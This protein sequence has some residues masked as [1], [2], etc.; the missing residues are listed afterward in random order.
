[1]IYICLVYF[2]FSIKHKEWDISP[3]IVNHSLYKVL[4]PSSFWWILEE[5]SWSLVLNSTGRILK[6]NMMIWKNVWQKIHYAFL[7][8]KVIFPWALYNASWLTFYKESNFAHEPNFPNLLYE[9]AHPHWKF[10]WRLIWKQ[11]LLKLA[12]T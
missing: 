7:L 3:V 2:L 5:V 12:D 10:L 1:M 4:S 8:A 6:E 11:N 9:K